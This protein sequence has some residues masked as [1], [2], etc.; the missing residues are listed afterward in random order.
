MLTGLAA[1]IATATPDSTYIAPHSVSPG[2]AG[3]ILFAGLGVATVLL[4]RSM[5]RQLRKVDAAGF[6][7]E[8]GGGDDDPGR[9][10]D[11]ATTGGSP[12]GS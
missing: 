11:A 1:A 12:A 10:T 2:L 6:P 4:W 7:G 9:T 8:R 3:F 5:N